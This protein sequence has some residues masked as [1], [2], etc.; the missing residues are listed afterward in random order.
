MI[1]SMRYYKELNIFCVFKKDNELRN[2]APTYLKANLMRH[3]WPQLKFNKF[4][5]A[6]LLPTIK[7]GLVKNK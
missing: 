1:M 2:T 7:T 5:C 4:N 3:T 6:R